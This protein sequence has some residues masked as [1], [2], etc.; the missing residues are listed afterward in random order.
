MQ[1][2][3]LADEAG[4]QPGEAHLSVFVSAVF[5]PIHSNASVEMRQGR[6]A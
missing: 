3:I 1:I 5:L 4:R 2:P 6:S